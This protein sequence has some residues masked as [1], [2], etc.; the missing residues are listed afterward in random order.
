MSNAFG[1]SPEVVVVV[2]S[3]TVEFDS[4]SFLFSYDGVEGGDWMVV[5]SAIC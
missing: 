2:C 3:F 4:F 5:F 1:L